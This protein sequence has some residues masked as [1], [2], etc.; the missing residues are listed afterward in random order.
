VGVDFVPVRG[1]L[2]F[3]DGESVKTV[4]IPIL[5]DLLVEYP[6][7]FSVVLSNPT[8]G[9]HFGALHTTTISAEVGITDNDTPPRI[10]YGLTDDN[11]LISFTTDR[12]TRCFRTD[13][14]TARSCSALI[15]DQRRANSTASA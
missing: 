13:T 1:T 3:H 9:A 11:R 15:F 6:E 5:G 7:S 8:G 12:R 10:V 14:S 2:V 4:I